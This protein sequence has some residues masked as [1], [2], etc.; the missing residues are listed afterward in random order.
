M[1]LAKIK[2]VEVFSDGSVNFL[3]TSFRKIKQITFYEKDALTLVMAKKT[4]KIQLFQSAPRV[5]Y[6]SKYKF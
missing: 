6:K 4:V 5:S 1:K 3:Y 2:F